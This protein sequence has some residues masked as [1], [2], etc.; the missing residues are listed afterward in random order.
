MKK[1]RFIICAV[2][3][4]MLC[5]CEKERPQRPVLPETIRE[6]FNTRY[7]GVKI[8]EAYDFT[9][10]QQV[11]SEV[12]FTDGNKFE[13]RAFYEGDLWLMTYKSYD[14]ESYEDYLPL[15]V[16]VTYKSL[17]IVNPEFGENDYVI[18]IDRNGV[19]Q[20][21]YEVRCTRQS[22]HVVIA[23]DGTL[24]ANGVF[25]N[26]SFYF[27]DLREPMAIVRDAYPDAE[28]LGTVNDGGHNLFYIRDNGILK[29]VWTRDYWP[30]V[31][32]TRYQIS[33]DTVLPD[34]VREKMEEFEAT[35]PQKKF[36]ALYIVE[37]R[38]GRFYGLSFGNER[39]NT[40]IFV[41]FE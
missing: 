28:I 40:T 35:H 11:L 27:Y 19:D 15:K 17:N 37:N 34:Y 39:E 25:F 14:F 24:L 29:S 3:A 18:E 20:K 10:D 8:K 16:Q 32:E 7:P 1:V 30:T 26:T 6:D 41:K 9:Y 22:R 23:E 2:M 36:F 33:I 12:I 31:W 21:Q 4:L 13:N 38:D 5:A